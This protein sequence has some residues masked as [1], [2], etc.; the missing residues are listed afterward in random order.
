M[1]TRLTIPCHW[2]E[3][4]LN[5]ILNQNQSSNN[6]FVSEIYGALAKSPI[7]HGRAPNS[8][9]NLTKKESLVFRRLIPLDVLKFTYLLNAPFYY[10]KNL[11][12]RRITEKYIAWVMNDFKPDAVT[13]SSYELMEIVR[14][15]YP[16]ISINISTIAGVKSV[17]DLQK[18]KDIEPQRVIL[19]HDSNRNFKDLKKI[20]KEARKNNIEVELMA[21]ES[22]LRRCPN[23]TA[24]Y[25]YLAHR[26]PDKPFH[27]TCNTTKLMYPRE[28]LKANFIRPEDLHVYEKMSIKI[29][30]ITGRS[31]KSS[32]LPEV[33]SAYI[34]RDY[35]GNLIRLLGIDPSLKAEDWI[36]IN[37]K[38]LDGFLESFPQTGR[39]G[40]EN[41]YC[42][43][44]IQRL[45]KNK[46]FLMKDGSE[47]KVDNKGNLYC[48]FPGEKVS[49]FM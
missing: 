4:I 47:Y 38:A 33:V 25:E 30:K 1:K 24:H 22:C 7:G 46:D 2:D 32:W 26:N 29:F 45:Y 5:K 19:H 8:V 37:N 35:D 9:P 40:D 31:K 36:F 41:K 10:S 17:K 23:R 12:D 34:K 16:G 27:T 20:I 49:Q 3:K 21:T 28:I 13:I 11:K 14:K 6:V 48:R 15:K 42:E 18:F 44:W 43:K 39:E